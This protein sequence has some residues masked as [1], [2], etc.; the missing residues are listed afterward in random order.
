MRWTPQPDGGRI[1]T[2]VELHPGPPV[3]DDG[4]RPRPVL[5]HEDGRSLVEPAESRRVGDCAKEDRHSKGVRPPLEPEQLVRGALSMRIDRQPVDGVS[6]DGDDPASLQLA[7]DDLELIATISHS[8]ARLATRTR[9][10]PAKSS[11]TVA[12]P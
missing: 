10:R 3:D 9:E 8:P 12:E 5:A 2:E 1:A 4:E 11:I 7:E 6:R